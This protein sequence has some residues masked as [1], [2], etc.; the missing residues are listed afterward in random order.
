VYLFV[1]FT[2]SFDTMGKDLKKAGLSNAVKVRYG[3]GYRRQSKGETLPINKS[4]KRLDKERRK[5]KNGVAGEIPSI[6][7]IQLLI[8]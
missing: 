2:I 1:L 7:G 8:K 5:D 3:G 6:N 4:A